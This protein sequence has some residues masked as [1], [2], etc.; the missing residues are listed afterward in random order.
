VTTAR[1]AAGAAAWLAARD[2]LP[3]DDSRALH[4]AFTLSP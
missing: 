1:D 4:A 3:D 2:L